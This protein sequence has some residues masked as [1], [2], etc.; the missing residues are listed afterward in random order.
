MYLDNAK[1]H[2]I[3]NKNGAPFEIGW[4]FVYSF[5]RKLDDWNDIKARKLCEYNLIKDYGNTLKTPAEINYRFEPKYI[6]ESSWADAIFMFFA[7][8]IFAVIAIEAIR[9]L[10]F[11]FFLKKQAPTH[12]LDK[13]KVA[14][15][16]LMALVL[17]PLLFFTLI[18][19]PSAVVFCQRQIARKVNNFKRIIFRYGIFPIPE[20]DQHINSV[21]KP[22]YEK[23]LE[24]EGVSL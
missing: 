9:I 7:T 15:F 23:C 6:I 13:K 18:K 3:C 19:K 21:I 17:V 12:T 1:S 11:T 2:I 22:L 16:I 14:I 8:F 10:Y 4:N 5:E 20:E 24:N